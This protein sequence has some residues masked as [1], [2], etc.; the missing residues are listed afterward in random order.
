[1]RT[2][3]I[4]TLVLA[5]WMAAAQS[6]PPRAPAIGPPLLLRL[7]GVLADRK[8]AARAAGF[9]AVSIGFQRSD[10]RRWLGVTKA[11]T[12]GGDNPLDGKDVIALVAPFDPNFLV[13]GP[14]ELVKRIR[15]APAGTALRIEGLVERGS[16]IFQV[17]TVES[18]NPA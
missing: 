11:R 8:S 5:P 3:L 7:E 9:D 1:M 15:D 6:P 17:R 18:P 4:L 16:R 12:V 2:L 14:D 13:A 10:A